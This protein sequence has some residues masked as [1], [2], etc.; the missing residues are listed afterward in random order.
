[1]PANAKNLETLVSI[2]D[3]QAEVFTHRNKKVPT[4][5]PDIAMKWLRGP[6]GILLKKLEAVGPFILLDS[7]ESDLV[8]LALPKRPGRKPFL[9]VI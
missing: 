2:A 5:S 4:N 9:E 7:L 3:R 8:V 6:E 1:M